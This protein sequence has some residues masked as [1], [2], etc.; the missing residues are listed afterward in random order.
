VSGVGSLENARTLDLHGSSPSEVD[1]GRGVEAQA[2]VTVLVVVP[3]EEA[4]TERA[5]I[6]DRTEAMRE[7]RAVLERLE[8]RLG[9]RIVVR[10]VRPRVA[11]GDAR[12]ASSSATGLEAIE[13]HRSA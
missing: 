11:L 1:I 10:A 12:S 9:I 3:A 6:L 7:L 2:R 13:V 4:L 8:L 5:G